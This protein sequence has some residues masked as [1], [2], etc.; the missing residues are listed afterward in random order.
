MFLKITPHPPARS[1]GG[2]SHK[3]RGEPVDLLSLFLK[4]VSIHQ[5]TRGEAKK[6][7]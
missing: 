7:A 4:N 5:P 2:L 6:A 3:G 1:T